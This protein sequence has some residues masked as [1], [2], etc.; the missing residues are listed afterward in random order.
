MIAAA[1]FFVI[2]WFGHGGSVLNSVHETIIKALGCA[3]YFIP[4]LLVYLSVKIFRSEN[5]RVAVPVYI[6]SFLM[7]IWISGIGAIWK[8]GGF[9]GD[10]LNG[11]ML[12]ALD[13]GF[14]IFIYIILIFITTAFVLQLSPITFF[15]GTKNLIKPNKKSEQ[16]D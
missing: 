15:K 6:A 8:A 4:A 5:N 3:T 2:A 1:L 14:V 10:W 13:Q 9:V 11:I 7:I 12:K 16:S